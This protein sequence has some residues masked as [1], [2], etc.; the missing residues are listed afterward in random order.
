MTAV[1]DESSANCISK[2]VEVLT[3][4]RGYPENTFCGGVSVSQNS[5][6]LSFQASKTAVLVAGLEHLGEAAHGPTWPASLSRVI[7]AWL[8]AWADSV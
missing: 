8:Y 2:S 3:L 1:T 7:E 5:C 4:E 6:Y